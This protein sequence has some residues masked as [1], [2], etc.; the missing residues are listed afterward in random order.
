MRQSFLAL[1]TCHILLLL[2]LFFQILQYKRN[3][4][5]MT[6]S[7]FIYY[8][9]YTSR[10]YKRVLNTDLPFLQVNIAWTFWYDSQFECAILF[11]SQKFLD[12]FIQGVSYSSLK[13]IFKVTFIY[14]IRDEF[15]NF[16]N[17]AFVS[18]IQL[19]FFRCQV[20]L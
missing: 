9:L 16:T 6:T 13:R 10:I 4:Q 12:F 7:L 11:R 14:Q 19:C 20:L 2:S 3:V 1:K 15:L 5:I 18:F 17:A 8:D